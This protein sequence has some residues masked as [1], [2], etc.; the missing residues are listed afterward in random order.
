[1][2]IIYITMQFKIL[3]NIKIDLEFNNDSLISQYLKLSGF[4][5]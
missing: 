3:R 1:M 2:K 4:F 5:I